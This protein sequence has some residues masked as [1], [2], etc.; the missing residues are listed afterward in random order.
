M[1]IIASILSHYH[2][3]Q[4]KVGRLFAIELAFSVLLLS[5]IFDLVF[6][7]TNS[8]ADSVSKQIK[9]VSLILWKNFFKQLD[10][11]L[12]SVC[13]DKD[14]LFALLPL[15]ADAFGAV[16]IFLITV[17]FYKV[18]WRVQI[19]KNE[20]ERSNFNRQKNL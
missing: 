2:I 9:I 15:L 3:V 4:F 6:I 5:E 10:H 18:Q 1:G 12:L 19:T 20:E 11:L 7:L 8:V 16:I 13:L 17:L 14:T